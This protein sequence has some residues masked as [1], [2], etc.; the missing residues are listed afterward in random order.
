M[1]CLATI[2]YGQERKNVI[3]L[4]RFIPD[5]I[6][7]GLKGQ[8][9]YYIPSFSANSS[10]AVS[11][12]FSS[13]TFIGGGGGVYFRWDMKE[14]FSFQPEV[15]FHYRRGSVLDEQTF[16]TDTF[17][18]VFKERMTNYEA[19]TAEIPLNV[20]WRWELINIG[21]GHWKANSAIGLFI[22][23]RVGLALY[24]R[25]T[26]DKATTTT[27]YDQIESRDFE[28]SDVSAKA[29]YAPLATMGIGA[30]VDLELSYGLILQVSYYRGLLS[31][32]LKD[33]GYKT[34]DN[35]IEFGIGVRFK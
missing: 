14:H 20:K 12:D 33:N 26:V 21:K 27:A 7:A 3:G 10:N 17:L 19:V 18:V 13:N 28:A 22:G 30:G 16:V 8:A 31:H 5:N 6:S 25:Q 32:S 23:P 1:L 29:K 34:F 2:T 9:N 4:N 35:R 15:N 11:H 24:S